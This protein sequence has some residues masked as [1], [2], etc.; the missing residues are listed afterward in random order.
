MTAPRA[1]AA[2]AA[3]LVAGALAACA[4]DTDPP[5]QLDHDRVI[6]VR[7]NPP[8]LAPG[9]QATLDALLARKGDTTRTAIP[10]GATV[11]SPASLADVV[12]YRGDAWLVTAPSADRL[13]AAR[14]ELRLPDGAPVP[15]V[16]GV[17]FANRTL[18]ATKT[19][20][21]GA[22]ID[23]PAL[24][25]VTID[26]R[27]APAGAVQVGKLVDVPLAAPFDDETHDV[28][29]LT[30]C[31]TMHDEDLPRAYLRVEADD[32]DAGE[33]VVVLRDATGGVAWSVWPIQAQ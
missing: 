29:W 4:D 30:S 28:N 5:W 8:G 12:S 31:G 20:V 7:A 15:L 32:R 24:T 14:A 33:L 3:V 27:A 26:G 23:N 13:A 17:A 25:G 1:I 6:A 22:H 16:V 9:E 10:E 2:A 18:A 21:L 11:V 19:I